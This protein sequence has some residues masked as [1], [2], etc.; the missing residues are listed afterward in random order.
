VA[1]LERPV[2]TFLYGAKEPLTSASFSPDGKHIL[3][4]SRDGSV[5]TYFCE[6]CGGID[7]LLAVADA[8][9][10]GLERRLTPQERERYL[11]AAAG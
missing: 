7:E 6:V 4:S 5:R 8:R 2:V 9:L 10:A 11:G 1:G 3:T